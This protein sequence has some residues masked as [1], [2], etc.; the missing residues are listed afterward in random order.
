MENSANVSQSIV[1]KRKGCFATYLG[2]V[3]AHHYADF[4]GKASVRAYWLYVLCCNIVMLG[5]Y[6]IGFWLNIYEIVVGVVSLALLLPSLSIVVRRLHD[7][8]KSGGWIFIGLIPLVGLIWLLVLLCKKGETVGPKA[9]WN[10]WDTIITC[11]AVALL[12]VGVICAPEA[13]DPYSYYY[14]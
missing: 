3:F 12:I 9:K 14:Y 8:G 4:K 5:L 11:V 13:Y 6:G 7:M 2:N 10:V 1:E